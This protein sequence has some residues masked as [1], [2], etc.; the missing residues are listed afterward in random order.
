[1]RRDTKQQRIEWLVGESPAMRALSERVAKIARSELPVLI[2]GE[3]G[4]GKELVAKA[5]HARSARASGPFVSENCAALAESL[6]E[7]ELFGH[8]AGAFTGAVGAR[9]GLFARA[10]GGTLFL[11]EV[12]DMSPAM[13][14]KLL[15]VLQE[16]ELRPVGGERTRTVD[17][18]VIAATHR[19]LEA[20]V[21]EGRFREDLLFRLAVLVVVVP[22]LRERLGDLPL[23]ADHVL[24]RLARAG[25]APRLVLDTGGLDALLAHDWPGNVRELENVLRAAALEARD[26]VLDAEC[27]SLAPGAGPDRLLSYQEVLVELE[28]RERRFLEATLVR[29]YGNKTEAAR[30]LGISRYA[31]YRA[32][33]RL[34]IDPPPRE[35]IRLEPRWRRKTG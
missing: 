8:E 33:R 27:L 15:R 35:L 16:G 28:A 2:Q 11:D 1:M 26:G 24:D 3:T 25:E 10:H 30:E 12:G 29:A 13:Q 20:L 5:I 17:V 6:L 14:A 18:R 19:D 22:P 32:I 23:L 21:G 9:Q 7:G 31:L 34:G 4:T